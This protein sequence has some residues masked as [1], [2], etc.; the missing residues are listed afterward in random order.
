[1]LFHF[2]QCLARFLQMP[3][4]LL[5]LLQ[6]FVM[7]WKAAAPKPLQNLP[8]NPKAFPRTSAKVFGAGK[9]FGV[10][11]VFARF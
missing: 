1:M 11:G 10:V 3:E 5:G 8:K 7:V 9:V 2:L 4:R 6:G